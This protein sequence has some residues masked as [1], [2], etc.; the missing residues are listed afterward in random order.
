MSSL[1][2]RFVCK[3]E[4]TAEPIGGQETVGIERSVKVNR[5]CGVP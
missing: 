1:D 5:A 4:E 3:Y 2:Q